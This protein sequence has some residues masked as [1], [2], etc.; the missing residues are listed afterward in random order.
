[1]FDYQDEQE[2]QGFN[3]STIP[4]FISQSVTCW[5]SS[6]PPLAGWATL[7]A[8]EADP[9]YVQPFLQSLLPRLLRYHRWWY[10]FRDHNGNGLAEYGSSHPLPPCMRHESGMDN[11]PRFDSAYVVMNSPFSFS[12]TQ[13]SVDLNA[14]LYAEKLAL[15]SLAS[16]IGKEDIADELRAEATALRVKMQE[17]FYSEET[18]FMHDRSLDGCMLLDMG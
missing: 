3:A 16:A 9:I 15:A 7:G 17:V 6:N 1:M 8:Y 4:Y 2:G 12:G 5:C 14:F 18:G 10:D 13:E 11:A